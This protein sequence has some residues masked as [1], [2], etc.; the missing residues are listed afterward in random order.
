MWGKFVIKDDNFFYD[1]ILY[2]NKGLPRRPL[3]FYVSRNRD[4]H[5]SLL[6]PYVS[7]LTQRCVAKETARE[8]VG[9]R[10]KLLNWL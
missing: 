10:A 3:Y 1:S 9:M 8:I 2:N 4:V 5:T 7:S 6:C